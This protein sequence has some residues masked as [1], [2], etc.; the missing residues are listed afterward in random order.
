MKTLLLSEIFPPQTGGSGRWFWEI[1]SRMP[2]DQFMI[3]AG[4]D[5][6]AVAFDRT[7]HL[8]VVRLPLSLQDWGLA[9]WAGFSGYWRLFRTIRK[10]VRERGIDRIHCGRCLPCGFVALMLNKLDGIPFSCYVHGEDANAVSLGTA[11]GVLSS[12]Q[13]RWMTRQ[14]MNSVSTIIANSRNSARI[15]IEQWGLPA[16]R[17][18]LLHPGCDTNYFVPAVRD[19]NVRKALGWGDR[20]VLL[21][22][23]RLQKR[24]GHDMMIRA[25]SQVREAIPD[26]LFAIIGSGEELEPL[27]R[28]VESEGQQNH[29]LFHGKLS[30]EQLRQ[31]YQQAD[32]FVLANR[33]I[34]TDIEGFGMVLLE[35]QACGRPVLAGDSGGTAE[36]MLL[37]ETGEVVNCDGPDQ[38][39]LSL[40]R[41]LLDR[42]E[43]S[44][45][46]IAARQWVADHFDWTALSQQAAALFGV[47]PSPSTTTHHPQIL[48]TSTE[49]LEPLIDDEPIGAP[50]GLL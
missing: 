14:V 1:Y 5:P 2:R 35:S 43:L 46:G 45:R 17:V 13:L 29:V 31:S 26:V 27:Q 28:L 34:G 49:P 8:D 12:R 6:E 32:L 10:I 41:L 3:A 15:A 16:E 33:Q 4:T 9:S 47:C 50:A 40:I 37:G 11:D 20:P 48:R 19:A 36:T 44:R 25:L 7:H 21:T 18:K 38:L 24:K 39:A 23:G 30:D 42:D 22:V